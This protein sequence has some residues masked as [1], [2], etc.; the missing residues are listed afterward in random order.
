MESSDICIEFEKCTYEHQEIFGKQGWL[1][2]PCS[3]KPKAV[4]ALSLQLPVPYSRE[5]A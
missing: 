1:Q 5:N 2:A 4:M 3:W